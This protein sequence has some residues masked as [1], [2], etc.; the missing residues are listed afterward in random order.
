[1]YFLS[2]G[3]TDRILT[4]EK[5]KL[6]RYF[7]GF[8]LLV[9]VSLIFG[10]VFPIIKGIENNLSPQLLT[11]SRYGFA[12]LVLSPLLSN[13]N[14]SL[15]RD[16]SII[17][18]LCFSVS[19]LSCTALEGISASRAGFT[20]ALS[21]IFVTLLEI[22]LGIISFCNRSDLC[23]NGFYGDRFDVLAQWGTFCRQYLDDSGCHS[24]FCL[25]SHYRTSRYRSFSPSN[26]QQ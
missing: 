23:G 4:A 26:S 12:A 10:S 18:L 15:I 8:V 13:L 21:I 19:L 11:T 1:M 17:G 5:N 22:F 7:L 2:I 16:G 25:Y 24:R 9:G 3:M 14:R 6:S 20:F